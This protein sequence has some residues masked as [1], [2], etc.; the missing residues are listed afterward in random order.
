[1]VGFGAKLGATYRIN[2]Q[3]TLGAAYHS[4]TSLGDLETDNAVLSMN[5]SGPATGG[6]AVTV[7]VTGKIAVEDFQWPEMYAL[8]GSY[9]INDKFM[10]AM[11]YKLIKWSGVMENFNMSFTA[12]ATQTGAAAMFGLGGSDL[13]VTMYQDWEDQSVIQMGGQYQAMPN[14]AVRAGVNVSSNP[15]PDE[16]MNPMFPAIIEKHFT[17]GMGYGISKESSIDLSLVI[18]PEVEQTN[19]NTGVTTT[20]SQQNWN[21]LYSYRF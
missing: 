19:S 14:L 21:L 6:N 17:L 4:K 9:K 13:S 5:V 20:H 12:D 16:Y 3:F 7:P 15:V 2:N 1:M 18:A 11:D 8:G 10:M